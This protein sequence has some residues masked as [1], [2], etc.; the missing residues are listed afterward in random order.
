METVILIAA[1]VAVGLVVGI[2]SGMLGVGGGTVLVP[3]FKLGFAMSA[4]QSTATSL[5]TIIPTSVSGVITHIRNR[6]CIPRLGVAAGIGGA[7][8]SPVGVWLA[9]ISPE[10]GIIAAASVVI[11]YSAYTA[12]SK[13][14]QSYKADKLKREASESSKNAGVAS[15][16]KPAAMPLSGDYGRREVLL[17][18]L[19]G[20][21]AGVVSGYVG[22]GGGFIMVPMMMQLLRLPMKLTSGT[23]LIAVMILAASATVVQAAMGNID[24]LAGIF[25]SMGSIP[26][27]FLGSRLIKR[28]PETVLRFLFGAFLLVAAVLLFMD[29]F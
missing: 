9:S 13:A 29:G 4:I 2:L 16:A 25:I 3:V 27:A 21:C 8:T 14:I 18:G 5:F 23:S 26:G 17:C 15:S 22:V 12:F 24:W 10:W 28:I 20:L 7:I 19:I 11:L 6:T 1:S